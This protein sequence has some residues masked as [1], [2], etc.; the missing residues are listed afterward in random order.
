MAL[1]IRSQAGD[2][3]PWEVVRRARFEDANSCFGDK[4]KCGISVLFPGPAYFLYGRI[5][6]RL[7]PSWSGLFRLHPFSE[8]VFD[9]HICSSSRFLPAS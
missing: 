7:D 1:P 4:S 9:G 5:R 6:A 8:T 2:G 3:Y